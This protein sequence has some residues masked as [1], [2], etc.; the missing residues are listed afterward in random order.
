MKER[1]AMSSKER[2]RLEVVKAVISGKKKWKDASEELGI[3]MRQVG[4][5]C[6]RVRAKGDR[7]VI[8]GLCGKPSNN[9]LKEKLVESAIR[10]VKE[11]YEDFGPTFA[12]EK[13]EAE[14]IE[15][16]TSSLRKAMIEADIWKAGRARKRH[17]A[18]R[19]RR[20]KVGMMVLTDG[21]EHPWFEE[22]G[23]RCTL[24]AFIDDATSALK[25]LVF[26]DSEDTRNLMFEMRAYMS[27][28]GRPIEL[29]VDRDSIYKTSRQATVEEE[30][31]DTVP[32]TQFTRAMKELN[33]RVICALSPQAKG[34]V[35][36]VF[37]TLQDRLVKELRLAGINTI[38]AANR[39]LKEKYLPAHNARF[40]QAPR[41]SGDAH[42]PLLKRHNI[43]QILSI[44]T[45]RTVCN[46][47]T[48]RFKSKFF[49]LLADQLV[50]I[51]PRKT[52]VVE[53]RLDGSIHISNKS[54][55]LKY[56][57]LPHRPYKPYYANASGNRIYAPKSG[58][59]GYANRVAIAI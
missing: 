37:E 41:E 2:D 18:W 56:K 19:E 26:V 8:H 53:E 34:R 23:K 20:A 52:V 22:R 33:I 42:R 43:D 17:R 11:R 24:L 15:I 4:Y 32:D 55:Y 5:I 27:K 9:R 59:I 58:S 1:L 25:H 12:N 13:L 3:G 54:H 31:K 57:Q 21:S 36:R 40:A 29:Y 16:S 47:W 10:M 46:D 48:I 28:Y 51:R 35:E 14:G 49:Q 30:L 45:K 44:Q 7:G 6:G 50:R 38:E 39:F